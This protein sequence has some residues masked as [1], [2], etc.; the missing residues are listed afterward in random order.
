[1]QH[2]YKNPL[3]SWGP[4]LLAYMFVWPLVGRL[5]IVQKRFNFS[6]PTLSQYRSFVQCYIGTNIQ[7]KS[8]MWCKSYQ[9]T[10][11]NILQFS[12]TC[13]TIDHTYQY[14][15]QL[16][17]LSSFESFYPRKASKLHTVLNLLH[18]RFTLIYKDTTMFADPGPRQKYLWHCLIKLKLWW[19]SDLVW[20]FW[21]I[22]ASLIS[23]CGTIWSRA[24]L[25]PEK[26]Y[27]GPAFALLHNRYLFSL[28]NHNAKECRG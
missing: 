4:Q 8:F 21:P 12:H 11:K 1:M 22:R 10:L 7:L 6:W 5:T 18:S 24:V 16:I 2:S 14:S 27:C 3:S 13:I 23:H 19:G 20:R 9:A 17:I 28:L 15:E 26:M 25:H